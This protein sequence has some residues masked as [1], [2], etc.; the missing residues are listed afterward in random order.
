MK[1]LSAILV[2]EDPEDQKQK[3][4]EKQ[5]SWLRNKLNMLVS[6]TPQKRV[7]RKHEKGKCPLRDHSDRFPVKREYCGFRTRTLTI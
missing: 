1:H 2:H 5:K 3:T 7:K 4:E 6:N